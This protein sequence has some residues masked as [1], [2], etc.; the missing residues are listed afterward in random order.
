[1]LTLSNLR[2]VRVAADLSRPVLAHLSRIDVD[3]LREIE[4]N[5]TEPWFDE[6][7]QLAHT[8]NTGSVL[9]LVGV[10]DAADPA[11]HDMAGL[12]YPTDLDSWRSGIRCPLSLAVRL[13]L[14]FGLTD[15]LELSV[16]P[17]HHQIW[18]VLQA[19]ERVLE[20]PGW[21]PWCRADV[22]G[23]E[24]H[25]VL[26]LPANL[27]TPPEL[28]LRAQVRYRPRVAKV[29]ER[30]LQGVPARGLK[31]LRTSRNITQAQMAECVGVV[32]NH[33]ARLERGEA[34]LVLVKARAL[35]AMFNVDLSEIY[36]EGVV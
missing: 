33:Y 12:H 21:C 5:R 30:G 17:I 34:G 27:W 31:I 3:R 24:T 10:S 15:P 29:G 20:G 4:I 35:A 23:G 25:S 9:A 26:C 19:G 1:M 16:L 8:F 36:G 11:L 32:T 7:L 6:A 13:M 22:L 28:S 2:S 14:R 18:D